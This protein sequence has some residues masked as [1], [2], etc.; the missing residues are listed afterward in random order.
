MSILIVHCY[1]SRNATIELVRRL[2]ASAD[3]VVLEH[4]FGMPSELRRENVRAMTAF[5]LLAPEEFIALRD[6]AVGL[7]KSWFRTPAEDFSAWD[8]MSLGSALFT[9]DTWGMLFPRIRAHF[10]ARRILERTQATEVYLGASSSLDAQIWEAETAHAGAVFHPLPAHSP[11]AP[12]QA[13]CPRGEAPRSVGI[14]WPSGLLQKGAVAVQILADV[15]IIARA[16]LHG[17]SILVEDGR[18]YWPNVTPSE[19]RR[20]GAIAASLSGPL[21]HAVKRLYHRRYAARISRDFAERYRRFTLAAGEMSALR[22]GGLS[23]ARALDGF[24]RRAF[25]EQ[26]PELAIEALAT[27]RIVKWMRPDLF[28]ATFRNDFV[29]RGRRS[30]LH[31]LG[32][33]IYVIMT[34]TVFHRPEAAVGPAEFLAGLG[35]STREWAEL[36]GLPAGRFI[37][38]RQGQVNGYGYHIQSLR[39]RMRTLDKNAIASKVGVPLERP[40]VLYADQPYQ[41]NDTGNTPYRR[42]KSFEMLRVVTRRYPDTT[43]VV[44]FHP[45]NAWTLGEGQNANERFIE[46]LLQGG[47][48]NV[49]F[50][51]LASSYA[52]FLALADIVIAHPE[53]FS[54]CESI[55]IGRPT[56]AMRPRGCQ[57][58]FQTFRPPDPA[59]IAGCEAAVYAE[60]AD[61]LSAHLDHILNDPGAFAS[62]TRMAAADLES[63]IYS[64]QQGEDRVEAVVRRFRDLISDKMGG[65]FALQPQS[66]VRLPGEM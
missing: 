62:R 24:F 50:A 19:L 59:S 12:S 25:I 28:V 17:G 10:I 48:R 8:G 60:D 1:D 61:E 42:Y 21:F 40:I 2:S 23:F 41:L 16:R 39:A 51:P 49:H 9:G 7:A 64:A 36:Q 11:P 31:Q 4:D 32:V 5:D 55:L 20:H 22:L 14:G 26:F 47:V 56:I 45:L 44:K 38:L 37:T 27:R 65:R 30:I 6:F 54:C 53:S 43:F 3:I 57:P 13:A 52:E 58:F 29:R 46:F 66:R 33:K 15:L 18:A 35:P 34:E 63:Y